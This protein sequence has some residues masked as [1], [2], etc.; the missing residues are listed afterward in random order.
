MAAH[1]GSE[2]VSDHGGQIGDFGRGDMTGTG[3][4]DGA[5]GRHSDWSAG[6][7]HNP[8]TESRRF[9]HIVSYEH[10]GKATL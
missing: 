10:H 3:Q 7:Q 2:F 8:V 1:L 4:V 6:Q 9:T 5:D